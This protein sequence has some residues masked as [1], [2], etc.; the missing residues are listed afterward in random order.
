MRPNNLVKFLAILMLLLLMSA[1]VAS[2][3]SVQEKTRLNTA[4]AD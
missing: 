1:T 2:A 4:D 3:A